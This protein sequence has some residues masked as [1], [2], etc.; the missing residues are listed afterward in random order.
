MRNKRPF[1]TGGRFRTPVLK[2]EHFVTFSTHF[3]GLKKRGERTHPLSSR[4]RQMNKNPNGLYGGYF[5][6]GQSAH[7]NHHGCPPL[8]PCNGQVLL[9]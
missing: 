9:Q 4:F 3:P 6:Q 8:P 2:R 1:I 7:H 5:R